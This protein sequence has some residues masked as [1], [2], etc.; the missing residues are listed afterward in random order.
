ML[1]TTEYVVNL[2]DGRSFQC[3]LPEERIDRW[4]SQRR[5]VTQGNGSPLLGNSYEEV[6]SLQEIALFPGY[7]ELLTMW[8]KNGYTEEL[9]TKILVGFGVK[10]PLISKLLED[11]K[12]V[13]YVKPWFSGIT[14]DGGRASRT[15]LK[16]YNKTKQ[17]FLL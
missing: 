13:K 10:E 3:E 2:S 16:I 5:L 11:K 6:A 14:N 8:F 9:M 4:F 12:Y 15:L 1:Y 17:Y 7:Q